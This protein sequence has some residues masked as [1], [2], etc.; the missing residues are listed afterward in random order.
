MAKSK[1]ITSLRDHFASYFTQSRTKLVSRVKSPPQVKRPLKS[2]LSDTF[3]RLHVGQFTELNEDQNASKA[4]FPS[5]LTGIHASPHGY[6]E[7]E[8][9]I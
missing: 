2:H 7:E 5:V 1:Y 4:T 9:I 3:F 6:P 8:M